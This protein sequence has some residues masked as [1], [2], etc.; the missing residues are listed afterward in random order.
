MLNSEKKIQRAIN[1]RIYREELACFL[2]GMSTNMKTKFNFVNI[3]GGVYTDVMND[4]M[5]P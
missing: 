4:I 3:D 2:A 5:L 1:T